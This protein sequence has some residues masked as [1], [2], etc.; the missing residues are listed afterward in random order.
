MLPSFLWLPYH[1]YGSPKW[2][3]NSESILWMWNSIHS[4]THTRTQQTSKMPKVAA[5]V[6]V[7]RNN[8]EILLTTHIFR[9]SDSFE[10]YHYSFSPALLFCYISS[11]VAAMEMF[12]ISLTFFPAFHL[13]TIYVALVRE[14]EREREREKDSAKKAAHQSCAT[15]LGTT[16]E[17]IRKESL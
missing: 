12:K 3:C 8:F 9:L 6:A 14:W 16:L 17:P 5:T 1:L 7:S 2:L 11:I 10:S 13:R 4:S 15:L